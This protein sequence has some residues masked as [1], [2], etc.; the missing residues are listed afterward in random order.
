MRHLRTLVLAVLAL[1]PTAAAQQDSA[2]RFVNGKWLDGKTFV[3]SSWYSIDGRLTK[4]KPDSY[5]TV[6]LQGGFVIPP[7]ADAHTHNLDGTRGLDEMVK[8]YMSEGTFYVQVLGNYAS[9]AKAAKERLKETGGPNV[10]Y[11][12][13]MITS[14][15]GHPFMVYEPLSLGIYS[16]A[17]TYRRIDEVMKS[18]NGLGDVYWFIDSAAE[19]EKY[20]PAILASKPDLIKIALLDAANHD[21]AGRKAVDKGLSP[22]VAGLVVDRAHKAG[23]RV[24]AHVET[25]EDFRLGLRI[26][27]DGFAHAPNY[28]W[29]GREKPADLT[30]EDLK[31]AAKRKVV[32]IP[33]AARAKYSFTDY[34]PNGEETIDET[35]R[36]KIISRHR[37]LFSRMLRYKVNIALGFDSYGSTVLP[38]ILYLSENKVLDNADLLKIA[39][40]STPRSIFPTRKIG[41]FEEGY[42]SSFLVLSAD[43]LKDISAIKKIRSRYQRGSQLKD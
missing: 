11:A 31:A 18:R 1:T 29:D 15:Y 33:T 6:D 28:G 42:E 2:Y 3:E 39:T 19:V 23:L 12:N 36:Q 43:P 34:G 4:K 41:G 26:G 24:F 25:A 35:R 10:S 37:D 21:K 40:M 27:V 16:S 14:T 22:K 8:A 9:G 7:F 20:F 38:E 5:E 32:I 30:D 13:G 17:D